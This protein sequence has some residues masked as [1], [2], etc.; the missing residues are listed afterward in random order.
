MYN[1][2][3]DRYDKKLNIFKDLHK[4]VRTLKNDDI[5]ADGTYGVWCDFIRKLSDYFFTIIDGKKDQNTTLQS[6]LQ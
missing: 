3:V 2:I 4:L 6:L 5:T 1:K